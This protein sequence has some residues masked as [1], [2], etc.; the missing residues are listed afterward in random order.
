MQQQICIFDSLLGWRV[1]AFQRILITEFFPF[2]RAQCV[3]R[4]YFY[5]L[6]IVKRLDKCIQTDQIFVF[7]ASF[8]YQYMSDPHWF[9]DF[10]KVSCHIQNVPVGLTSED[11][12][13]FIIDVFDIQHHKIGH[14]QKFSDLL[15]A[16]ALSGKGIAAGIQCGV[17]AL[18]FG[19]PE[20]FCQKISSSSAV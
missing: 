6:Y 14:F 19:F 20:K 2:V 8:R 3:I 16:L 7:V 11:L 13:L 5:F 17:D 12:M 10:I 15:K 1:D 18:G 9:S 4:Q